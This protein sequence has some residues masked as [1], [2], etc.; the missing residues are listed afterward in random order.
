MSTHREYP[1]S[2]SSSISAP[3]LP[4]SVLHITSRTLT[5][6]KYHTQHNLAKNTRA[7]WW[8]FF[9][10]FPELKWMYCYSLSVILDFTFVTFNWGGTVILSRMY[11]PWAAADPT[12]ST[13]NGR[14]MYYSYP[15]EQC[16]LTTVYFLDRTLPPLYQT[17]MANE[18]VFFIS[19]FLCIGVIVIVTNLPRF[20]NQN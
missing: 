1:I 7:D 4:V 15:L 13:S 10:S 12:L 5:K 16:L 20:T 8:S 18:R 11:C 19:F 9:C 3:H 6:T 2:H 17:S 14:L